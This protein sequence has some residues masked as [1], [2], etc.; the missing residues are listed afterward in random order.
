MDLIP[1]HSNA[2]V[3]MHDDHATVSWPGGIYQLSYEAPVVD[4]LSVIALAITDLL[5]E[6]TSPNEL[7]REKAKAF[8]EGFDAGWKAKHPAE[9]NAS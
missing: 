9:S 3:E 8:D 2:W 6:Y 4:L 1:L 5:A 7:R